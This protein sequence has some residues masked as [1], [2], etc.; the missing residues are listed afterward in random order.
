MDLSKEPET[1]G[2]TLRHHRASVKTLPWGSAIPER[3][4]VD[5]HAVQGD[6]AFDPVRQTY[7]DAEKERAALAAL[8]AQEDATVEAALQKRDPISHG[9]NLV[10]HQKVRGGPPPKP[11]PLPRH[12]FPSAMGNGDVVSHEWDG[13]TFDQTFERELWEAEQERLN[14]KRP[15]NILSNRFNSKHDVRA[16]TAQE[17]AKAACEA[18]LQARSF[19]PVTMKMYNDVLERDTAAKEAAAITLHADR[20][21][22]RE[23]QPPSI[24]NSDSL[25]YDLVT[26]QAREGC[27]VLLAQRSKT[28]AMQAA[29]VTTARNA[30]QR[31]NGIR[32]QIR[33]EQRAMNRKSLAPE[34]NRRNRGYDPVTNATFQG[35][36]SDPPPPMRNAPLDNTMWASLNRAAGGGAVGAGAAVGAVDAS[37]AGGGGAPEPSAARSA[38]LAQQFP[39]F[40]SQLDAEHRAR[41]QQLSHARAKTSAVS[42]FNEAALTNSQ[43]RAQQLLHAQREYAEQ[44]RVAQEAARAAAGRAAAERAAKAGGYD[45]NVNMRYTEFNRFFGESREAQAQIDAAPRNVKGRELEYQRVYGETQGAQAKLD[46]APRNVKGRELEFERV[47]GETQNLQ[48]ER[49]AQPKNTTEREIEFDALFGENK[50][51]LALKNPYDEAA[52]IGMTRSSLEGGA[53]PRVKPDAHVGS[54]GDVPYKG[55]HT[56]SYGEGVS[57]TQRGAPLQHES[58]S[59]RRGTKVLLRGAATAGSRSRDTARNVLGF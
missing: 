43:R 42:A 39:N 50:E 59:G 57:A 51:Y 25:L 53:V 45:P 12:R 8:K 40:Q 46:A 37:G 55:M 14:G 22:W 58:Y 3:I 29:S 24:K 16:A 23:R 11:A 52:L 34:M 54:F 27:E 44:Q 21:A 4:V 13:Q 49:D 26:L 28:S 17:E 48:V 33:D 6:R 7:R 5:L 20:N 35:L 56:L 18:R 41:E 19:N 15:Y 32:M 1:W 2:D 36:G 38:F 47:Y 31:E 9:Y 30:A 10:T